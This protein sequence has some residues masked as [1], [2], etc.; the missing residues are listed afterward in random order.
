[1]YVVNGVTRG[2]NI[3]VERVMRGGYEGYVGGNE[4]WKRRIEGAYGPMSRL[5][6]VGKGSGGGISAIIV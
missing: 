4:I 1:M 3:S 6:K 5:V 2:W